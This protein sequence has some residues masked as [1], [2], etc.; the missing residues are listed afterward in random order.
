MKKT[1]FAISAAEN[2][3]S[4]MFYYYRILELALTRFKYDNV[5]IGIDTRFLELTLFD[6]GSAILF[7]SDDMQMYLG[8]QSASAGELNVYGLPKS[9]T[10]VAINGANNFTG[11]N[12]SN[13]VLIFNNA[14][15]TPSS[16]IALHYAMLLWDIDRTIAVNARAQKTPVLITCDENSRLTMKNVYQQYD[17]NSPVIFG[18]NKLKLDDLRVLNTGAPYLCDK[19][20]DLKN[21]IWNECLTVLGISNITISK[22]ERMIVDEVQRSQGGVLA[23]RQAALTER[24]KACDQFNKIFGTNMTVEFFDTDEKNNPAEVPTENE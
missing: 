14:L 24:K 22:R 5:P 12:E 16:E 21:S 20:T 7:Y 8:L 2:T 1:N 15:H 6:Y 4:Y 10:A 13:S 23:S 11:L 3:E 19:L 18:T 17:G 9:R